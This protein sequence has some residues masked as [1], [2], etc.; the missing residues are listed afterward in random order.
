MKF[1]PGETKIL[2]VKLR[3]LDGY[4]KL[5]VKPW[6]DV[7][8]DGKFYET[9]PIA[10]PIKLSAGEHY[11]K[12]INP[13]FKPFEQKITIPAGKMLKKYVELLPK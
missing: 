10:K 8:I 3:E 7:Y 5:T 2:D 9:T 12:L 4:L 1:K 13:S 6:A 11:I